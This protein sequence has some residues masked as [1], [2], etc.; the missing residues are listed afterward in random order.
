MIGTFLTRINS[1]GITPGHLENR[2]GYQVVINHHIGLLHQTQ[3]TESQQVGISGASSYQVHLAATDVVLVFQHLPEHRRC[4]ALI[5]GQYLFCDGPIQHTLP[6]VAA[7]RG[8]SYIFFYPFAKAFREY[9]KPSVT[10]GD[11]GLK[12]AAQHFA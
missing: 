10:L 12:F 1:C 7:L 11:H 8:I 3:S 4:A 2:L 6:E 5:T 9:G